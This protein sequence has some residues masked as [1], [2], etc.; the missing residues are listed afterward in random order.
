MLIGSNFGSYVS[1]IF[2]AFSFLSMVCAYAYFANE[3]HRVASY[4]AL[5]FVSIYVTM[6]LL[7]YFARIT[8]VQNGGLTPQAQQLL[9]FQPFG[10]FFNYDLFGYTFM[11]LSTFFVGLTVDVTLRFDTWL[12][13]LLMVH[14][15][16]SIG[17]LVLPMLKLFSSTMQG[18]NW[19][20]VAVLEFLVYLFI[21]VGMLSLCIFLHVKLMDK[22]N[23]CHDTI[24]GKAR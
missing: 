2:I 13:R 14:G 19:I 21:P 9:D 4:V 17:C 6:M 8:I 12:K 16:F 20:S 11:V 22:R 24:I 1:S 15:I 18:A 5:C 10:L 23:W 7:V 3:I